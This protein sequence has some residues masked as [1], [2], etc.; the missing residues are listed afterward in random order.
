MGKKKTNKVEIPEWV[1]PYLADGDPLLN[2]AMHEA[3]KA[4][5]AS[6]RIDAMYEAEQ[7]QI[8]QDRVENFRENFTQF[9][10]NTEDFFGLSL[11]GSNELSDYLKKRLTSEES[12]K[13]IP[14]LDDYFKGLKDYDNKIVDLLQK[15]RDEYF[16]QNPYKFSNNNMVRDYLLSSNDS[17]SLTQEE[18][19]LYPNLFNKSNNLDKVNKTINLINDK[20]STLSDTQRK[21]SNESINDEYK[22]FN[23]HNPKIFYPEEST[24]KNL[25]YYKYL[26]SQQSLSEPLSSVNNIIHQL[27]LMPLVVDSEEEKKRKKETIEMLAKSK[28]S[29][30]RGKVKDHFSV[31]GFNTG[32]SD[33]KDL[34]EEE[35]DLAKKVKDLVLQGGYKKLEDIKDVK[36]K[37]FEDKKSYFEQGELEYLKDKNLLTDLVYNYVTQKDPKFKIESKN[38]VNLHTLSSEEIEKVQNILS[39]RNHKIYI[40]ETINDKV[41]NTKEQLDRVKD[42]AGFFIGMWDNVKDGDI[43]TFGFSSVMKDIDDHKRNEQINKRMEDKAFNDLDALYLESFYNTKRLKNDLDLDNRFWYKAGD[44]T[45]HS[46]EFIGENVIAGGLLGSGLKGLAKLGAKS[47]IRRIATMSTNYLD[48]VARMTGHSANILANRTFF[49]NY[50]S[51]KGM[52]KVGAFEL[53]R[54]VLTPSTYGTAISELTQFAKFEDPDNKKARYFA[55]KESLEYFLN[56]ELKYRIEDIAKKKKEVSEDNSISEEVRQSKLALLENK[57]DELDYFTSNISVKNDKG[58][59]ESILHRGFTR[60]LLSA[61]E[62]KLWENITE[63]TN[64]LITN[65]GLKWALARSVNWNNRFINSLRRINYRTREI[66][67]RLARVPGVSQLNNFGRTVSGLGVTRNIGNIAQEYEEEVIRQ[68]M[69]SIFQRDGTYAQQLDELKSKE[70]WLLTGISTGFI[71][72]GSSIINTTN[73]IFTNIN[74]NNR[75]ARITKDLIRQSILEKDPNINKKDLSKAVDK[76][77]KEKQKEIENKKAEEKQKFHDFIS[78]LESEKYNDADI[79]LALQNYLTGEFDILSTRKAIEH[80]EEVGDQDKADSLRKTNMLNSLLEASKYGEIGRFI[81]SINKTIQHF[82]EKGDGKTA[83]NLK[84]IGKIAQNVYTETLV[85]PL[86]QD[87]DAK[88]AYTKL[89]V[90]TEQLSDYRDLLEKKSNE[91][92]NNKTAKEHF[93]NKIRDFIKSRNPGFSDEK[94]DNIVNNIN[95]NLVQKN[96]YRDA[97][98]DLLNTEGTFALNGEITDNVIAE[99]IFNDFIKN[100]NSKAN[101]NSEDK[102]ILEYANFSNSVK[103]LEVLEDNLNTQVSLFAEKAKAKFSLREKLNGIEDQIKEAKSLNDILNVYINY[104]NLIRPFEFYFDSGDFFKLVQDNANNFKGELEK[105]T[106]NDLISEIQKIEFSLDVNEVAERIKNKFL[107]NSNIDKKA[108]QAHKNVDISFNIE[109][110]VT[111]YKEDKDGKPQRVRKQVDDKID[112]N[113]HSS[114]KGK[115]YYTFKIDDRE[116]FIS[117]FHKE[118]IRDNKKKNK[119]TFNSHVKKIILDKINDKTGLGIQK[120][121]IRKQKESKDFTNDVSNV[122]LN[123]RNILEYEGNNMSFYDNINDYYDSTEETVLN[124]NN[125]QNSTTNNAPL[126]DKNITNKGQDDSEDENVEENQNLDTQNDSQEDVQQDVNDENIDSSE[127]INRESTEGV[128]NTPEFVESEQ[129][130]EAAPEDTTEDNEGVSE[131]DV[132]NNDQNGEKKDTED[133][134]DDTEIR[135]NF[136]RKDELKNLDHEYYLELS[137]TMFRIKQGLKLLIS[138][139]ESGLE[140]SQ[141]DIDEIKEIIS[142]DQEIIAKLQEAEQVYQ[143]INAITDI[144]SAKEQM[145]KE[146]FK[147]LFSSYLKQVLKEADNISSKLTDFYVADLIED[148]ISITYNQED[149]SIL[150]EGTKNIIKDIKRLFSDSIYE[151][152][153][154]S[155]IDKLESLDSP[156]FRSLRE[157]LTNIKKNTQEIKNNKPSYS[158]LGSKLFNK[159]GNYTKEDIIQALDDILENYVLKYDS[160]NVFSGFLK[161][162]EDSKLTDGE[163]G[164]ILT[165]IDKYISDKNLKDTSAF[166]RAFKTFMGQPEASKFIFSQIEELFEDT[167]GNKIEDKG[168]LMKLGEGSKPSKEQANTTPAIEEKKVEVVNNKPEVTSTQNQGLDQSNETNEILNKDIFNSHLLNVNDLDSNSVLNDTDKTLEYLELQANNKGQFVISYDYSRI[169]RPLFEHFNEGSVFNINIPFNNNNRK[170]TSVVKGVTN[171]TTLDEFL[172][173]V[174]NDLKNIRSAE[175]QNNYLNVIRAAYIPMMLGFKREDGTIEFISRISDYDI[176]NTGIKNFEDEGAVKLATDFMLWRTAVANNPENTLPITITNINTSPKFNLNE[177]DENNNSDNYLA[178][179]KVSDIVS[180]DKV[181]KTKGKYDF[182]ITLERTENLNTT[183]VAPGQSEVIKD[184]HNSEEANK[185]HI[186][187]KQKSSITGLD[188]FSETSQ[189]VSKKVFSLNVPVI[190]NNELKYQQVYLD[191]DTKKL[192]TSLKLSL[193]LLLIDAFRRN[194]KIEKLK[195][196]GIS[197]DFLN[198]KL[199]DNVEEFKNKYS[200]LFTRMF[201]VKQKGSFVPIIND[202]K[203]AFSILNLEGDISEVSLFINKVIDFRDQNESIEKKD[204]HLLFFKDSNAHIKLKK[205]IDAIL[206]IDFNR[207][208]EDFKFYIKDDHIKNNQGLSLFMLNEDTDNFEYV[209]FNSFQEFLRNFYDTDLTAINTEEDH[210]V[211][212][213]PIIDIE[214]VTPNSLYNPQRGVPNNPQVDNNDPNTHQSV[215]DN[216]NSNNANKL[217]IEVSVNDTS[218]NEA[219]RKI[220]NITVKGLTIDQQNKLNSIVNISHYDTTVNTEQSFLGLDLNINNVNYVEIVNLS[221]YIINKT[222]H[223]NGTKNF[224]NSFYD[225]SNEI[226][227]QER[228]DLQDILNII[229]ELKDSDIE[230]IEYKKEV[231]KS[232]IKILDIIEQPENIIKLKNFALNNLKRL[233]K[234]NTEASEEIGEDEF[235]EDLR[236]EWQKDEFERDFINSLSQQLKLLFFGIPD[237]VISPVTKMS[238]PTY[239]DGYLN[240]HKPD[241]VYTLLIETFINNNINGNFKRLIEVLQKNYEVTKSPIYNFIIGRLNKLPNKDKNQLV[242]KL[243]ATKQNMLGLVYT[244]INKNKSKT[245]RHSNYKVSLVNENDVSKDTIKMNEINRNFKN[246]FLTY[247]GSDTQISKEN[248]SKIINIFKDIENHFTKLVRYKAEIEALNSQSKVELIDENKLN[249]ITLKTNEL[250]SNVIKALTDLKSSMDKLGFNVISLNTYVSMFSNKDLFDSSGLISKIVNSKGVTDNSLTFNKSLVFRGLFGNIGNKKTKK[251]V[252]SEFYVFTGNSVFNKGEDWAL[253]SD[254]IKKDIMYSPQSAKVTFN[255]GGKSISIAQLPHHIDDANKKLLDKDH[256]QNLLLD[257]FSK[258][259]YILNI[260]SQSGE[261]SHAKDILKYITVLYNTSQEMNKVRTFGSKSNDVT[262]SKASTED[263]YKALFNYYSASFTSINPEFNYLVPLKMIFMPSVVMSDKGRTPLQNLPGIDMLTNDKFAKVVLDS[264][265]VPTI[266]YTEEAIKFLKENL[267]YPELNTI[268]EAFKNDYNDKEKIFLNFSN[269]N[270]VIYKDTNILDYFKNTKGVLTEE[271]YNS[272]SDIL[273]GEILSEID[274]QVDYFYKYE[275]DSVQ[276]GL[277]V[278][279]SVIK[280][281]LLVDSI[282]DKQNTKFSTVVNGVVKEDIPNQAFMKTFITEFIINRALSNMFTLQAYLGRP[283]EFFKGRFKLDNLTEENKNDRVFWDNLISKSYNANAQKRTALMIATG[284]IQADSENENMIHISLKDKKTFSNDIID[285]IKTVYLDGLSEDQ[286]TK[287]KELSNLIDKYNKEKDLDAK[288]ILFKQITDYSKYFKKASDFF[289]VLGVDAQMYTTWQSHLDFLYRKGTISKEEKDLYSKKISQNKI[290]EEEMKALEDLNVDLQN[291]KPVY[292]GRYFDEELQRF[293][294]VYIKSSV[295]VLYPALTKGLE[296]DRLRIQMEKLATKK[297]PDGK[298]KQVYASYNSANKIGDL[299][300]SLDIDE[301]PNMNEEDFEKFSRELPLSSF[302]LQQETLSKEGKYSNE[303]KD[304]KVTL[305]SQIFKLLM[306]N[307]VNSIDS[308]IFDVEGFD[309]KFLDSISP[310]L[311]NSQKSKVIKLLNKDVEQKV[312]DEILKDLKLNGKQLDKLYFNIYKEYSDKIKANLLNSLGMKDQ[313]DFFKMGI[314]EKSN[315]YK[316]LHKMIER[317]LEDKSYSDN[318]KQSLQLVYENTVAVGTTIPLIFDGNRHKFESL[319][320][321]L[322]SNRLVKH[323][324]HGNSHI[325]GSSEGFKSVESY[326]SLDEDTKSRIVF[327]DDKKRDSL[328]STVSKN[329]KLQFAEVLIKSHFKYLD[330]NGNLKYVDLTSDEYSTVVDG[331]RVLRQDKIDAELLK[332]FSFRIPTSSHQSGAILKVVGFLPEDSQDLLIVPAEHTVQIGEDYDVDKRYI[333]KENYF[334]DKDGN[335]RKLSTNSIEEIPFSQLN[336]PFEEYHRV[337]EDVIALDINE[338][339]KAFSSKNLSKLNISDKDQKFISR[340]IYRLFVHLEDEENL[341]DEEK[342]KRV[343]ESEKIKEVLKKYESDLNLIGEEAISEFREA[344]KKIWLSYKNDNY[345]SFK[346]S[347]YKSSLRKSLELSLVENNFINVFKAVYSSNSNEVQNKILKP[348]ETK[349]AEE[350]ANIIHSKKTTDFAKS[351]LFESI[352]YD[353]LVGGSSAKTGIGN[354]SNGVVQNSQFE[355]LGGIVPVEIVDNKTSK[356][357]QY[358]F[359]IDGIESNQFFGQGKSMKGSIRSISDHLA[360]MQNVNTDEVNKQIMFKRN[361]NTVTMGVYLVMALIG[362]DTVKFDINENKT[363]DIHIPSLFMSQPILFDYVNSIKNRSSV[364]FTNKVKEENVIEDLLNKYK[365]ESNINVDSLE[366]KTENLYSSLHKNV[367]QLTIEEKL[368]QLKVLNE[369]LKLNN[370]SKELKEVHR[371][372]N[373]SNNTLGKSYFQTLGRINNLNNIAEAHFNENSLMYKLIGDV[374]QVYMEGYTKIGKYFWKPETIEGVMVVN[375]L[376]VS[377]SV[378]QVFFDYENPI[379]KD[380]IE[381]IFDRLGLDYSINSLSDDVLNLKYYIMT[382][383]TLA[384]Q[385]YVKT[386]E[387]TVDSEISRLFMVKNNHKPLTTY[388]QDLVNLGHPITDNLLFKSMIFEDQ[389]S[390]G[391]RGFRLRN[392]FSDAISSEIKEQ[393]LKFLLSSNE[394]IVDSNNEPIL[395]NGEKITVRELMQDIITYSYLQNNK[396]S[397]FDYRQK[398]PVQYLKSIGFD[399]RLRDIYRDIENKEINRD[400]INNFITQFLQ[401]NS[402]LVSQSSNSDVGFGMED[403]LKGVLRIPNSGLGY[404]EMKDRDEDFYEIP[405][406]DN[407]TATL[408]EDYDELGDD[409]VREYDLSIDKKPTILYKEYVTEAT[410]ITNKLKNESIEVVKN[411]LLTIFNNR[412]IEGRK[413]NEDFLNYTIDLLLQSQTLSSNYKNLLSF[414]SNYM[415]TNVRLEIDY[416]MSLDYYAKY[417]KGVITLNSKIFSMI[418]EDLEKNKKDLTTST[419]ISKFANI[420]VEEMIHSATKEELNK[421]I[422]FSPEGKL[423]TQRE[424]NPTF[425][426]YLLDLYDLAKKQVPYNEEDIVTYPSSDIYEFIAHMYTN[427]EYINRL[428]KSK[429]FFLRVIEF[430]KSFIN[431]LIYSDVIDKKGNYK[432]YKNYKETLHKAVV[433]LMEGRRESILNRKADFDFNKDL[434]RLLYEQITSNQRVI[435]GNLN[436]NKRAKAI[437]NQ[438]LTMEIREIEKQENLIHTPIDM[439]KSFDNQKLKNYLLNDNAQQNLSILVNKDE[440]FL[441]YVIEYSLNPS[442]ITNDKATYEFHRFVNTMNEGNNLLFAIINVEFKDIKEALT[443]EQVERAIKKYNFKNIC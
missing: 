392:D 323:S 224:I 141:K 339:E 237:Y 385:N 218:V 71:S 25:G 113:F 124:I 262:Y 66:G 303:G 325:V 394:V 417:D 429:N 30:Y 133:E 76:E 175:V 328:A 319:I 72:G 306:S 298:V 168:S 265:G 294:T 59:Y 173:L 211:G 311:T 232:R 186:T 8:A 307:G 206:K 422:S 170:I 11:E 91:I 365:V 6:Q 214:D 119:F 376:S 434:S 389:K 216:I 67:S 302:R 273:I 13:A 427:S 213:Y 439:E 390:T 379:I 367:N 90:V 282:L 9:A 18:K 163:K 55:T 96:D 193:I 97:L 223:T 103:S 220:N 143:R 154:K 426:N 320:Q 62:A 35:I 233:L 174:A 336:I 4:S 359:K 335:I 114:Y 238:T 178:Y 356:R 155:I 317:E 391:T 204:N 348:L 271:D 169:D 106:A 349:I 382:E 400:I 380:M 158:R 289:E 167:N 93:N 407:K 428:E 86:Y 115:V 387:G 372:I 288:N 284:N 146:E 270:A 130:D 239:K 187:E 401:N 108:E 441:K 98:V 132:D 99:K 94:I 272:I 207:L 81:R 180:E 78:S 88:Q 280:N 362:V 177:E 423:I 222:L 33:L 199:L 304:A 185:F 248:I 131:D 374:S 134:E 416:N 377:N 252:N 17:L 230:G 151:E 409:F 144:D 44:V 404:D 10:I 355:R 147:N 241:V 219:K 316:K 70:F 278:E 89:N 398:V 267:L 51:L 26:Q 203:D 111:E 415:P 42:D 157:F 160:D 43:V 291:T 198:I 37:Y 28:L 7:Q 227:A 75:Q 136:N 202:V 53:G 50:F 217:P 149:I 105:L 139:L 54:T 293:K 73:N 48:D 118:Y 162:L 279:N 403:D 250:E 197:E 226:I 341:T 109:R 164:L 229:E 171:K 121:N 138:Q 334:V 255:S 150:L 36:K 327:L 235:S 129:Q 286:K 246:L 117:V 366:L 370:I 201:V 209:K 128:E 420:F 345:R 373:F 192:L 408:T 195:E 29:E 31:L 410:N 104:N 126:I 165:L 183:F 312:K 16:I 338:K 140:I 357:S 443:E 234:I 395:W 142:E 256:L 161:F 313:K 431:Y 322:I 435:A 22:F 58:E 369:F 305:G 358:K 264:S 61:T 236:E 212:Y 396:N 221:Q 184:F 84:R 85:N 179:G 40:D 56:K 346:S 300:N 125:N 65:V 92:V 340:E 268:L 101:I 437:N 337:I 191:Q 39:E 254:F 283:S 172:T 402:V 413:N 189:L 321:S 32:G 430:L 38:L 276:T 87:H 110:I 176:V 123:N 23:S 127:G 2:V 343:L 100:I 249:E 412:F 182:Q 292:T 296:I 27:G 350:T 190:K 95:N 159:D 188:T 247:D 331:R 361:E 45:G 228:K 79:E 378:N 411:K 82:E 299:T 405:F 266:E 102:A 258:D 364:L 352:Q 200:N 14:D 353:M 342:V 425:I 245:K 281:N 15:Y 315:V 41:K 386:Y 397:A 153:F 34:N 69:P 208:G 309:A 360:E 301:L 77:Y 383:F 433:E 330:E 308:Y 438:S 363:I 424:K 156:H 152:K 275:N 332:M 225:F 19:S 354:S 287:L 137:N 381:K 215:Q 436:L 80:F 318:Y 47:S 166:V 432:N 414:F 5:K 324:I 297:S 419:I 333:Y 210:K 60:E 274:K 46:L 261:N 406:V 64:G 263:F 231:I 393:E 112:L 418:V 63:R 329:G 145:P 421:Y 442:T 196:A 269:L 20:N 257:S 205:A 107:E 388:L 310:Y 351:F 347:I 326:E 344:V 1:K 260:I 368:T 290:T 83:D 399:A 295:M 24:I 285:I 440:E 244:G 120:L 242:S 375:S 240:Y 3:D 253:V 52:A 194:N 68:F 277:L 314:I 57:L 135:K 74:R 116:Y 148:K 181:S 243:S 384:I 371:N 49:S 21:N 259:S 251:V 12:Y 122:D